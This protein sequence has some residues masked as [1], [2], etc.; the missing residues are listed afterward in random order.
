LNAAKWGTT[1]TIKKVPTQNELSVKQDSQEL[2]LGYDR[3]RSEYERDAVIN[4]AN[5]GPNHSN[6]D[7]KG[8]SG[9]E[10]DSSN[11]KK[12][13][14][15]T[16]SSAQL[17]LSVLESG[18]LSSLPKAVEK[19]NYKNS[20]S[21]VTMPGVDTS[22]ILE[23]LRETEARLFKAQADLIKEREA[24]RLAKARMSIEF[25]NRLLS[26]KALWRQHQLTLNQQIQRAENEVEGMRSELAASKNEFLM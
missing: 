14:E 22:E 15:I 21:H 19:R 26:E 7:R 24:Q 17:S 20:S 18:T 1:G 5:V 9:T 25:E 2:S 3:R 8:Q 23:K 10:I 4:R 6:G 11:K 12:K 16:N 13:L